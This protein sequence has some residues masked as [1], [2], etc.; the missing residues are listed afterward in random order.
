MTYTPIKPDSGPSPAVDTTYIRDNFAQFAAIF[1]STAG[2]I[3]Y[4]HTPINDRNQGD[5]E[6]VLLEKQ[7][8]DPEVTENWATLYAKDA[9]SNA[10]IQP[11]IFARIQKFLPTNID[12]RNAQNT[13]M[14]LT[15][16]QVNTAGPVYQSFIPGGFL[17]YF[18]TTNNIA[19]PIT[20]SP[21]PTS[22]FLAIAAPYN[23]T[24]GNIPFDT[25]TEILSTSQFRINSLSATGVYTFGWVAIGTV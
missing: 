24:T 10:G 4:N 19:V 7:A 13:P 6:V 16:N 2:G 1:S 9:N 5:H 25:T 22:L 20:V 3:I 21:V 23:V 17:V 18:G 8:T 12:P 15:Y 11:Q 14:Q